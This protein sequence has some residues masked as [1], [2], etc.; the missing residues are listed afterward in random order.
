MIHVGGSNI[1][2]RVPDGYMWL[3]GDNQ[4]NSTDSR[5]YGP[6]PLALL[7]GRVTA[8]VW[9][10][11]EATPY[12]AATPRPADSAAGADTGKASVGVRRHPAFAQGG[13]SSSEPRA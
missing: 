8:R 2:L 13:G 5:N 3:E 7:R 4:H 10:L 9:P 12:S 11:T 1:R 6:V